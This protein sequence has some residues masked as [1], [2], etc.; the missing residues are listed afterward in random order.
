MR[1]RTGQDRWRAAFDRLGLFPTRRT[2]RLHEPMAAAHVDIPR[3]GSA[4]V[5]VPFTRKSAER[6]SSSREALAS[7][8]R[9]I[10]FPVL[11][12]K[13]DQKGFIEGTHGRAARLREH[14]A[15]SDPASAALHQL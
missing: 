9:S 2:L 1:R 10:E 3:S 13:L 6:F 14:L 11:P 8:A 4:R 5:P 15:L 7:L 12:S